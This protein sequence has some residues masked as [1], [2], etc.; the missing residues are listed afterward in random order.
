MT[1]NAIMQITYVM[2][3]SLERSHADKQSTTLLYC[4]LFEL[5][6]VGYVRALRINSKF[7]DAIGILHWTLKNFGSW[8]WQSFSPLEGDTP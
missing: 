5:S 6:T 8:C 2:S 1:P 4:S 3:L 7:N